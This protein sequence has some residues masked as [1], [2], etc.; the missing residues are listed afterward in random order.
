MRVVADAT[1]LAAGTR[2]DVQPSGDVDVNLL[3]TAV[4]ADSP[5]A[6]SRS[7]L[8]ATF[9]PL[10]MNERELDRSRALALVREHWRGEKRDLPDR[11]GERRKWMESFSQLNPVP[12][13]RD[14]SRI[15]L[16]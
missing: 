12:T 13:D 6:P 3:A 10:R 5:K 7:E 16:R 11:V 4:E 9:V 15:H 14:R 2:Q 8:A 1:K